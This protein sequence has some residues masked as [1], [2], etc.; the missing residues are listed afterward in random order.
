GES[1]SRT[2]CR[3][4]E[5]A[6]VAPCACKVRAMLPPIAP[7]APVTNAVFPV[8]SNIA[9]LPDAQGS[10]AFGF[11]P[12]DILRRADRGHSRR[13]GDAFDQ[14]G[15]HSAGADLIKRGD[16]RLSHE[17]NRFTPS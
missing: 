17:E 8:S 5:M 14:A 3:V 16:A 4:P 7:V 9:V 10:S 6:I 15:E 12:I 2:S 13:L 1:R 11:E